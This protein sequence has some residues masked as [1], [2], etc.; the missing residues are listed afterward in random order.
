MIFRR[1][2]V[3]RIENNSAADSKTRSSLVS[4]GGALEGLLVPEVFPIPEFY[5]DRVMS[6]PTAEAAHHRLE[7]NR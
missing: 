4:A 6:A 1:T 5:S 3:A 7:V 2:G